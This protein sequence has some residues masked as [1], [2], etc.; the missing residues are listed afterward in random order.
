MLQDDSPNQ[1]EHGNTR[2][3]SNA[4]ESITHFDESNKFEEGQNSRRSLF[5]F[6]QS[7]IIEDQQ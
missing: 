3:P 6:G 5:N 2:N 7:L 4:K 1:N